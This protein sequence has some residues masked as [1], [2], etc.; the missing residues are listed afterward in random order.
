[1]ECVERSRNMVMYRG[2]AHTT[3]HTSIFVNP[4]RQLGDYGTYYDVPIAE[5]AKPAVDSNNN[6]PL[7][8]VTCA[9]IATRDHPPTTTQSAKLPLTIVLRPLGFLLPLYLPFLHVVV[10][11]FPFCFV[12]NDAAFSPR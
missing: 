12:A 3:E 8:I 4:L 10:P 1:M 11:P 5:Y 7:G 9:P 6:R 2:L